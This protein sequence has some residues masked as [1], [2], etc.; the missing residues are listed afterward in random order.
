[1]DKYKYVI[2]PLIT[3]ILYQIIKFIIECVKTKKLV[4]KRLFSGSGGMPSSHTALT[5][6]LLTMIGLNIGVD[7]V[8]FALALVLTLIVA[9]DGMNVR[10][11]TGKH[12]H[13]INT[14]VDSIFI[15]NEYTDLKEELGHKPKEVFWGIILGIV[16]S[17]IY[18]FVI[19]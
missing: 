19:L 7:S 11:E 17:I 10:L 4:F 13:T 2:V 5:V 9:Y 1:M 12:A 18:T 14:L 6:S 8:Y 16:V 15:D 3:L